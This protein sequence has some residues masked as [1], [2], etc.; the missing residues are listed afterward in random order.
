MTGVLL[1]VFDGYMSLDRNALTSE[2]KIGG[3][4][5]YFPALSD[6]EKATIRGWTTCGVCGHPM[7]LLLQ[8]FSPLPSAP[9]LHHRMIYIF[10]CNSAACVTQPSCSWCAFTLQVDAVDENAAEDEEPEDMSR[11]DPLRSSELPPH[12]FPPCFVEIVAEPKKE[13]VVPTEL[14]AEMIRASEEKARNA[15]ITEADIKELERTIDLKDKPS[16][17]E[18]EK[19]RRRMAREPRQVLRYYVR[20]PL[21]KKKNGAPT[22]TASPLFM[23]PRNVGNR[24]RIPPCDSCGGALMHE[25]QL[26]PT[27]VYYLRVGEYIATGKSAT[28]EGVDWGSVTVFVCSKD[29]SKDCSGVVLRRAFVLVEKAPE[30]EDEARETDG[31]QNLRSFIISS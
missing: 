30:L 1:G 19:F 2:T 27:C 6:A 26:M 24:A 3:T 9:D 31:R 15:G 17:H 29:C 23:H 14:E 18:F 11:C 10:C 13:I 4:P 21:E 16:D 5:T 20:D 12:T 28:D 25:L 7:F 8:A 22:P